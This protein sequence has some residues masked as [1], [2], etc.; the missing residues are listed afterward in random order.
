MDRREKAFLEAT[1]EGFVKEP[2]AAGAIKEKLLLEKIACSY[3]SKLPRKK[4]EKALF[5]QTLYQIFFH[6][7]VP[8]YAIL[9]ES[10][11]LAKKYIHSSFAKFLNGAFRS[12]SSR[13]IPSFKD[14]S[15]QYSLPPFFIEKVIQERGKEQA[16]DIFQAFRAP[17]RLFARKGKEIIELSGAGTDLGDDLYIQNI[18]PIHL[19]FDL[20]EACKQVPKRVLDMAS[21]PG[22]KLLLA[23][24][25]FPKAKLFGNDVSEKKLDLIRENLERLGKKATLSCSLGEDL[26]FDELFDLVIADVPCSNTGVLHKRAE[27]R[28]RLSQ[29]E[30]D[31]AAEKQKQLVKKGLDLLKPDGV[32]FYMTCS[33]LKEENEQVVEEYHP[34]FQ[35]TILPD[36][37][38]LDGG[39]AALLQKTR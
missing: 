24:E 18:T 19:F 13:E 4:K 29:E 14:F 23:S 9:D 6:P 26:H 37:N 36:Q 7:E 22:G 38:G 32:L 2:I 5:D 16:V 27:A 34:L 17:P 39:F 12:I 15:I 10:Q 25:C 31:A 8:L 28:W 33:I 20:V 30:I 3:V 21:A 35:R 11:K 1:G